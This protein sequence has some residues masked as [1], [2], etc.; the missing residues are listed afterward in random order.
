MEV[1]HL[2]VTTQFTLFVT[3]III[4]DKLIVFSHPSQDLQM[5]VC[6]GVGVDVSVVT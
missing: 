2:T 6:V 1:R 5:R 3:S 4:Y